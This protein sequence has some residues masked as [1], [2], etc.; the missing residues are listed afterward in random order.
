M[1]A[2]KKS[3][4]GR[5]KG[6]PFLSRHR[7]RVSK[8]KAPT[9]WT[10]ANALSSFTFSEDSVN[11]LVLSNWKSVG[12]ETTFVNKSK[13]LWQIN[14]RRRFFRNEYTLNSVFIERY[15]VYPSHAGFDSSVP[16]TPE[17]LL[18]SGDQRFVF[19]WTGIRYNTR[20]L[21]RTCTVTLTALLKASSPH[22]DISLL[23]ESEQILPKD[24][25][26][27]ETTVVITAVHMP[28][29]AFEATGSEETDYQTIFS[30][31]ILLGH[32]Y[33]NPITHIRPHRFLNESFHVDYTKKR[34]IASGQVVGN[35]PYPSTRRYNFGS[36]GWLYAPVVVY[37]RRDLKVGTLIYALDPDGVHAKGFQW[38]S[39]DKNLH[40]RLYDSA[41][42]ELEYYG[43]GGKHSEDYPDVSNSYVVGWSMRI[44]PFVSP[45]KWVDWY[46]YELFKKEVVPEQETLG[47]MPKSFYERYKAGL[48]DRE[49]IEAPI[50]I[51]DAGRTGG[52]ADDLYNASVLYQDLYKNSTNPAI[53]YN[54][55][56][57][58]HLQT[59]NLNGKPITG[60]NPSEASSNYRGW[61]PWANKNLGESYGPSAFKS[62][63]FTGINDSYSGVYSQLLSRGLQGYNYL[64][65]PFTITTGSVWT[66]SLSGID[67]VTKTQWGYDRRITNTTYSAWETNPSNAGGELSNTSVTNFSACMALEPCYQK[68]L[69]IAEMGATAGAGMYHDTAGIWGRGCYAQDHVWQESGSLVTGTHPRGGFT[70]FFNQAQDRWLSGFT[71]TMEE[72]KHPA[73]VG[74][75]TSEVGYSTAQASEYPGDALLKHVPNNLFYDAN[76]PYF[77]FYVN[78]ASLFAP[79]V[80]YTPRPDA[81]TTITS[82][83]GIGGASID[84]PNWIE[85]CPGFAIIYGDRSRL[86]D[87]LIP[88]VSNAFPITGLSYQAGAF[89][90]LHETYQT[91]VYYTTTDEFREREIAAATV[92][93]WKQ[94][95]RLTMQHYSTDLTGA[96]T[97]L[98]GII[99][100]HSIYM[101]G[102][103]S[104]YINNLIVPILRLQAYEPD[105]IYHGT[106]L[107][108]LEEWE[109]P[110][111]SGTSLY[112]VSRFCKASLGKDPSV[113]TLGDDSVQTIIKRHRSS[114]SVLVTLINWH[115]GDSTFSGVFRPEAYGLTRGYELYELDVKTAAHG[116]KTLIDSY[117]VDTPYEIN[118]S[119]SKY[120]FKVLEFNEVVSLQS[121]LHNDL[122]TDYSYV[123]YSYGLKELAEDD[124]VVAYSY[125]SLCDNIVDQPFEGYL[126]PITQNISNNLP[127]WMD[128]R[129]HRSSNGWQLINSWGTNLED[130]LQN[131]V[132]KISD[133][134]LT[135][136]DKSRLGSVYY[137][138]L[139]SEQFLEN[140][141]YK[142][143]LSN[144]SFSIKD[145]ART[146]LPAGWTDYNKGALGSVSLDRTRSLLGAYSVKI[147]GDGFIGQQV[148]LDTEPVN[149][150][151]ASCYILCDDPSV[152]ISMSISVEKLDGTS[153]SS[154]AKLTSRSAHWRRLALVLPINSEVYRLRISI[155]ADVSSVCYICAPQVEIGTSVTTWTSSVGDSLPYLASSSRFGPVQAHTTEAISSKTTIFPIADELE[156]LDISI[157]TRIQKYPTVSIDLDLFGDQSYGRRVNYF[158]ETTNTEWVV[159]NGYIV[160]RSLSPTAWDIYGRYTIRDLRVFDDSL[161]GT[162]EDCL[163]TITPVACAIKRD[164]LYVVC[165][166]IYRGKTLY[167]LKIVSPKVPPKEQT[168]LESIID[169]DLDLKFDL[170]YGEDQ[171]SDISV[172]S[173]GFSEVDPSWM[174]INTSSNQRVYYKLHLDYYYFDSSTNRVY[175][176]EDYK[177]AK[178]QVT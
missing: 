53:S 31:P 81:V 3:V 41:D 68:F 173:I 23:V 92:A 52:N 58:V 78:Y 115:S 63:D 89:S 140:R 175:T 166:E 101:T 32:T 163:G 143:L 39:D 130:T 67:L 30:A 162:R 131:I 47:W 77:P 109:T 19:R 104:G 96:S 50:L 127:P 84:P 75:G 119:L 72:I 160:E 172:T 118:I 147:K 55:R 148:L 178:I 145:V 22:L 74:S 15:N 1:I 2:P 21:E 91:P 146:N 105:Y 11:G 26:P 69:G 158:G 142:N 100:D 150:L 176:L 117:P 97:S 60:T 25:E 12:S 168:Y 64:I 151:A 82:G 86:F 93:E 157:P 43:M 83:D 5:S 128:I 134:Q 99:E 136:A 177:G 133:T 174:V 51:V 94:N 120:G 116:T 106:S 48:L 165:K 45:T 141:K 169:F 123:R 149:S 27:N 102:Q 56:L 35:A 79:V 62:P 129:K 121:D 139:D 125:D 49:N 124:V 95:Q 154:E 164:Y 36:P 54:T 34:V 17:L 155:R 161:Y 10:I 110:I 159:L 126:A 46:G 138:D 87:W 144:S 18:P 57:P 98:A 111:I 40:I 80:T 37:G 16:T 76:G 70:H 156:F 29:L 152:D 88:Q 108:P 9:T 107:H 4:G 33:V 137:F 65:F 132:S 7:L 24:F 103:F 14:A 66:Q 6:G 44:R 153:V 113:L 73:W 170:L 13:A 28:S 38:F 90:G 42:H 85:R 61:E 167:T 122:R 112:R 59:V 20:K 71:A 171:I 114:N 8:Y 135:L